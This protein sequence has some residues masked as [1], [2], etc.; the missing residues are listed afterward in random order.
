MNKKVMYAYLAGAASA[1]VAYL[2]TEKIV[3]RIKKRYQ[4]GNERPFCPLKE[5]DPH[6]WGEYTL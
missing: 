1:I 2:L 4:K 3:Q 5:K 6:A